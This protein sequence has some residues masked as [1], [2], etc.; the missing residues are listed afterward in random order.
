MVWQN[1]DTLCI[2]PQSRAC[3]LQFWFYQAIS[4]TLKMGTESIPAKV[5]KFRTLTQL[6]ALDDFIEFCRRESFKTCLLYYTV[7]N[8]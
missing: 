1:H 6:S 3:I 7:L 5:E 2:T 4:I 8:N